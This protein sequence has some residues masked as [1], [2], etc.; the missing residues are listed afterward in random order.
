MYVYVCVSVCTCMRCQL[1]L[2]KAVSSSSA[3]ALTC[4]RQELNLGILCRSSVLS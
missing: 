1:S 3:E 4:E 2:E